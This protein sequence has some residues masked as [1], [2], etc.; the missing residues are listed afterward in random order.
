VIE[1]LHDQ[2]HGH[3]VFAGVV[4]PGF[5][6]GM[7]AVVAFQPDRVTDLMDD[8]PGPLARKRTGKVRGGATRRKKSAFVG[9]FSMPW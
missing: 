5:P 9:S 4:A 7:R 3:A 6:E 2:L 8:L 1:L